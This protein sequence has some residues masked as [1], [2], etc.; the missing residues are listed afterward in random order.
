GT[1]YPLISPYDVTSPGFIGIHNITLR[2]IDFYTT[3]TF[4]YQFTFDSEYPTVILYNVINGSTH[5]PGKIIEVEIDDDFGINNVNYHWDTSGDIPWFPSQGIIYQ[6]NLPS[7]DGSHILY[8]SAYDNYNHLT[9]REF[10][11]TTDPNVFSVEL[12]EL[13]NNSYY[14]GGEDVIINVQKSN[15]TIRYVWDS[16]TIKDGAIIA[17]QMV[18]NE[19]EVLPSTPGFHNLTIITFNIL[20]LE[21]IIFFNFTVDQTAPIIDNSILAN[22]NT[23][24]KTDTTFLFNITDNYILSSDLVI[25][26]SID[27]KANQT[28][29]FPYQLNLITFTDGSHEFYLYAFDIAGNYVVK[30][31]TFTVDT[32]SPTFDVSIPDSID[33]TSIDGNTYVPSDASVQISIS[34]DDPILF[35]YYSWNGS[36]LIPFVDEFILSEP[37][38]TALLYIYVEDSLSNY[39]TYSITLTIDS[40]APVISLTSFPENTIVNGGTVFEFSVEEDYPAT[41]EYVKYYWDA[42]FEWWNNTPTIDFKI[43]LLPNAHEFYDHNETATVVIETSDLLGNI[44]A[45]SFDF[46]TDFEA[47][48]IKLYLNESG[49]LTE[50]IDGGSYTVTGN[51]P[52]WYN[53]SVNQDLGLFNYRWDTDES[54]QLRA[55]NNWIFKAIA[56][57]GLHVL[58][59]DLFDNI[60]SNVP[61]RATAFY[62]IKVDDINIQFNETD[63][64]DWIDNAY[65]I[66]LNYSDTFSFYLNV[67]DAVNGTEILDLDTRVLQ[68][69]YNFIVSIEKQV[70]DVSYYCEIQATNIT[71]GLETFVEFEFYT[72]TG[73]SQSVT[74]Y[75][76]V[77]KK[78]G[79][80]SVLED[81]IFSV[82]YGDDVTVFINLKNHLGQNTSIILV[83]VNSVNTTFYNIASTSNYWFNYSTYLLPKGNHSFVIYVESKFHYAIS[84]GS[85]SFEF[86]VLPLPIFLDIQVSNYT[87]L[88][89]TQLAVTGILTYANGTGVPLEE[90][91]FY[92]YS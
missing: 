72:S 87:V 34:D 75:L 37:D 38:G 55:S 32:T 20:N 62:N 35:S 92:I 88:E 59:V 16:G 60:E 30:Y 36:S 56:T 21:R 22:N 4:F 13:R 54:E 18:L 45:Y 14:Q 82:Y 3:E 44:A 68:Q 50:L 9:T 83:E 17:G 69:F 40:V 28:L 73:G 78:L 76:I 11:F 47:P 15:G 79:D 7:E 43:G 12:A 31:I 29:S 26:I 6:T 77:D 23:R 89:G 66:R 2:T 53:S 24:F 90:I 49:V 57:D 67:T 65:S 25:L 85:F 33:F 86:E 80:L 81:S 70:D 8:I 91:H 27:G 1:W 74:V 19:T 51:T 5:A 52:I 61:N 71:N 42:L 39:Q 63:G 46:I 48:I 64:I 10:H 84:E 58:Q 41:V